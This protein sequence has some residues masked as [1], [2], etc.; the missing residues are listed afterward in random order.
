MNMEIKKPQTVSTPAQME[1]LKKRF[2]IVLI[3]LGALATYMNAQLMK[4]E[5]GFIGSCIQS[6][7]TEDECKKAWAT[8]AEKEKNQ[9]NSK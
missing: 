6:G 8:E 9:S 1:P 5:H 3:A 7:N 4:T 2:I